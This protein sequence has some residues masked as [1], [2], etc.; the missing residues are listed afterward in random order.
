M[1]DR[2]LQDL[3]NL[4][5]DDAAY[6]IERLRAEVDSWSRQASDRAQDA[7][8]LVAAARDQMRA[9]LV[10]AE[11]ALADI[12]DRARWYCVSRDGLA[13]L[14]LNEPNAQAMAAQNGTEFPNQ[15]PYK[16]VALGDIAAE[17]AD[18]GRLL[19]LQQASY[20]REILVE[21]EIERERIANLWAGCTTEA[22]GHGPV[23]VG[24]SIRAGRLI[25]A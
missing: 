3:R 22:A 25:D 19:T 6:E 12:G 4:G 11:A 15:A 23:D 8:D 7:L 16:A 5:Y 10:T 24:A 20:E 13:M 18:Y 21:V 14:C 2:E 1:T 17:R 9:A